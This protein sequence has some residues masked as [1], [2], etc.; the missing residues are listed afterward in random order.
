MRPPRFT[1]LYLLLACALAFASCSSL[2]AGPHAQSTDWS[3]ADI[4]SIHRAMLAGSLTA[5]RLV[6]DCGRRIAEDAGS[7][8]SLHA[9]V[10]LVPGAPTAADAADEH[11]A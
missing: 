3:Q 9:I 1:G 10:R 5:R 2:L 7:E 6:D 4:A 8:H 11:L